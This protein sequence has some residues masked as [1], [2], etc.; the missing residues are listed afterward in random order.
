MLVL[1]QA[2]FLGLAKSKYAIAS[3]ALF[4]S[5][6]RNT[7]R[8]KIGRKDGPSEEL[9]RKFKCIESINH[10]F[11]KLYTCWNYTQSTD[12]PYLLAP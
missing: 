2:N 3:R 9:R 12:F 6:F 7:V 8:N 11:D 4:A 1:I 5:H 10:V